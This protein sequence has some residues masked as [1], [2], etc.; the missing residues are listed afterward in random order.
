M[1]YQEALAYL[2]GLN[3]FGVRLGFPAS[4][5]YSR[6]SAIRRTSTAQSM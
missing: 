1:N 5:A 4:S 3:V 2:D 6:S